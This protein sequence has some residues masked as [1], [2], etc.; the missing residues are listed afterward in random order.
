MIS[1]QH[2]PC[3][4]VL[5]ITGVCASA[6]STLYKEALRHSDLSYDSCMFECR[7][8]LWFIVF[9]ASRR[10]LVMLLTENLKSTK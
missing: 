6:R 1:N 7:Q 4:N 8:C 2:V 10:Q 3:C 5:L 9:Y